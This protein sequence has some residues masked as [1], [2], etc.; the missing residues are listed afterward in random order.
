LGRVIVGSQPPV[1][2]VVIDLR[3][4]HAVTKAT[5]ARMSGSERVASL[6]PA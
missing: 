5:A 2:D 1:A 3:D 4:P 6:S